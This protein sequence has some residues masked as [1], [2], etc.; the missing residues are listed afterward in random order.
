MLWVDSDGGPESEGF[1]NFIFVPFHCK[2]VYLFQKRS[3]NVAHF[4]RCKAMFLGQHNNENKY[5]STFFSTA[6]HP[7]VTET[8][9][10]GVGE[11]RKTGGCSVIIKGL[12]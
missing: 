8:K 5:L 1:G 12:L 9:A 6:K 10:S 7:Q 2:T 4:W 3:I 11:S